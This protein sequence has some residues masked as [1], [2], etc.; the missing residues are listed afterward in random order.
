MQ[1]IDAN[2]F[3]RH[4]TRDDPE[5]AKACFELFQKA[6]QG[7]IT[8]TTSEAVVAE[9]VF[10][11]GPGEAKIELCKQLRK[12]K[13]YRRVLSVEAADRMTE[14]QLVA[15]VRTFFGAPPREWGPRELR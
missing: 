4:L 10:V 5:K 8:L 1:F 15:K 9:V 7:E 12:P 11:L 14:R 13:D 2:V 3:I 6:G